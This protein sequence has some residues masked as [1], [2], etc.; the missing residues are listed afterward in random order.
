MYLNPDPRINAYDLGDP[1]DF[2]KNRVKMVRS[3]L[4]DLQNRVVAKGEGWQ[5]ARS[6]FSVLLGELAQATVLAADYIGGEYTC[7]DHRGDAGDR[8][9]M[10]PIELAK[11]RDAIRLLQEEIL[12]AKAFEFKPE[13]LRYLAPEHWRDN[14]TSWLFTGDY[15]YPLLQRVLTVQRIVLAKFLGAET[16][17]SI[18]EISMQA[19]AGEEVLQLPEIFAALTD[20]IWTELP[21]S[22]G[23]AAKDRNVALSIIRRNLQRDHA[24]RLARMVVGP[25]QNSM[26]DLFML[27]FYD[28]GR[29]VPP[30]ARSLAR[31]HLRQIDARIQWLL[32]AKAPNVQVD[33]QSRA[34]L[35]E[36]HEQIEKA[37]KAAL[38][39][40]EL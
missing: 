9:P 7:R 24:T 18:Q 16:L 20:S 17:R 10:K 14:Y 15:Q 12:S 1:L 6:A 36:V 25:R 2:A 28:N 3:S 39:V 35:E 33:A 40:N 4:D 32:N 19:G 23:D 13:L 5:R 26:M 27:I 22:E 31:Q 34:H 37:L 30:D 8:S 21:A 29:S 38:Q 11:Q